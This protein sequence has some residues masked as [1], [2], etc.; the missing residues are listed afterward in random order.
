MQHGLVLSTF[1]LNSFNIIFIIV[2]YELIFV[3]SFQDK[4]NYYHG[5]SE[6]KVTS[7]RERAGML[8]VLHILP[9][10]SLVGK[11]ELSI[12]VAKLSSQLRRRIFQKLL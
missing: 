3:A 8:Q 7:V 6:M 2:G 11:E 5:I 1:N 9:S 4:Y 10:L 12:Q